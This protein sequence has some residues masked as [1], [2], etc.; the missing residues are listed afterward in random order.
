MPSHIVVEASRVYIFVWTLNRKPNKHNN[1]SIL[2]DVGAG[3]DENIKFTLAHWKH[4]WEHMEISLDLF[5]FHCVGNY[6][7]LK[8]NSKMT[9]M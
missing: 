2:Y 5:G 1:V 7:F 9:Y 6:E 3:I 8:W 4:I